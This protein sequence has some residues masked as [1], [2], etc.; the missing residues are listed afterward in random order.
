[1]RRGEARGGAGRRE[2]ERGGGERRVRTVP[3]RTS[4]TVICFMIYLKWPFPTANR[5]TSP[6]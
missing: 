1:M 2:E 6:V 3:R 5:I 4:V